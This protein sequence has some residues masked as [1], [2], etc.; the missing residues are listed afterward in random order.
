MESSLDSIALNAE[1]FNCGIFLI[2]VT[3]ETR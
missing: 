2:H 1:L 3:V